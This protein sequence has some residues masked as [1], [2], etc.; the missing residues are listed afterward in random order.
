MVK[1]PRL[2]RRMTRSM[3]LSERHEIKGELLAG[4]Y[5]DAETGLYYNYY[6]DYDPKT[7]RYVESDP[8]GLKGGLNTY[9]YV[10]G[11]P[12]TWMDPS[13]EILLDPKGR[14]AKYGKVVCL[15]LNLCTN[16]REGPKPPKF[17]PPERQQ[18]ILGCSPPPKP[19]PTPVPD[20]V[21]EPEPEPSPAPSTPPVVPFVPQPWMY[22][23]P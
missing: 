23:L 15:F 17:P 2:Q 14:I 11:N 16:K 9:T 21:P 10:S 1:E 4:Q 12:I 13:G 19:D 7:G 20:P 6:R 5:A 8:V 3:D 18:S 22:L